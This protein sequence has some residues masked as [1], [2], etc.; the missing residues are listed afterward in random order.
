MYDLF[1]PAGLSMVEDRQGAIAYGYVANRV[2]YAR[3]VGCLSA[4]LGVSYVERLEGALK[5]V[6]SVAYFT[7]ASALREYDLAARSSF[8]RFVAERRLKFASI[9]ILTRAAAGSALCSL[10]DALGEPI[11]L[12]SDP[13]EFDRA[14]CN[15][16]PLAPGTAR[17]LGG[18]RQVWEVHAPR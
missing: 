1:N 16:A 9:A 18:V 5:Q 15:V 14:L 4:E 8:E 10:A 7:D 12:L 3:F 11:E 17:E 6:A 13:L 2:F